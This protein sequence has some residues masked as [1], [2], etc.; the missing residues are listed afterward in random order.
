MA[1]LRAEYTNL[2]TDV[3]HELRTPLTNMRCQLEAV[4]DGLSEAD[5]AFVAS[6]HEETLLLAR[7][8]EDLG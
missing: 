5:P 3:A 4:Q 2:V 6:L 1:G 8:V 7:L